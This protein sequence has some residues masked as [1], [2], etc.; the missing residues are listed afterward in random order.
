MKKVLCQNLLFIFDH[1]LFLSK[2]HVI[3]VFLA[4]FINNKIKSINQELMKEK[5]PVQNGVGIWSG[6]L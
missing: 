6:E 5:G 1:P 2:K 3:Y 4:S